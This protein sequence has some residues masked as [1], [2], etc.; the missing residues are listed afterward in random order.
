MAI[1]LVF[2]CSDMR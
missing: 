2:I 1:A